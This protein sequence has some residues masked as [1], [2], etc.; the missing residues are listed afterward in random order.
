M[1][2]VLSLIWTLFL[3]IAVTVLSFFYTTES[4]LHGFPFSFAKEITV[5]GNVFY[6]I[7]YWSAAIDIVIWWLLFSIFWIIVRNYILQVD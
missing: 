2:R 4:G 7:N 3:A 1:V 5:E 6:N